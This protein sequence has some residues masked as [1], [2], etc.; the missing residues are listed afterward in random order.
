MRGERIDNHAG[1]FRSESRLT[2][3][4]DPA[5]PVNRRRERS[6]IE[7]AVQPLSRGDPP[8][9]L[10]LYGPAGT[11]KTTLAKHVLQTFADES[12][13][14]TVYVNCWQYDTRSSLLPEFMRQ[15]GYPQPRK[16]YP[17]DELLEK[18][19]EWIA[20]NRCVAVVLD[21]F[22]RHR[23]QTGIIYDLHQVSAAANNRLGVIFIA[24]KPPTELSLD[25]RSQSRLNYQSVHFKRYDADD[26]RTIL[27]ERAAAAFR[28][29][30]VTED[31]ITRIAN[32]AAEVNGDCRY[33]IELLHRA[34]RISERERADAVTT[35][36]V[37]QSIKLVQT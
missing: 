17:V 36:H 37:I 19:Q 16:G 11:G 25:P 24:N 7:T 22:D 4:Y 35:D 26:L 33:A 29:N 6:R 18:L 27:Q 30:G 20:K 31:A 28:P 5:E 32:H 2:A 3:A 23:E 13:V 21:E 34:G 15:L 14:D 12:R 1:I 10:F 9:N 8:E